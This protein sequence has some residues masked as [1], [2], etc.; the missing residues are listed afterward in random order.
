VCVTQSMHACMQHHVLSGPTIRVQEQSV[1][2]CGGL[3]SFRVKKPNPE[4]A[5]D[6]RLAGRHTHHPLAFIHHSYANCFC[7]LHVRTASCGAIFNPYLPITQPQTH[8]GRFSF[9]CL[10]PC[11]SGQHLVEQSPTHTSILHNL[12]ITST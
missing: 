8:S 10:L 12:Y 7:S 11:R 6:S 2:C 4:S 9:L 5:I 3:I 1:R